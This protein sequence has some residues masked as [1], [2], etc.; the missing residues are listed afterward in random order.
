M[1]GEGMED[2]ESTR[3]SALALLV[4]G[5][6]PAGPHSQ[7]FFFFQTFLSFFVGIFLT[8]QFFTCVETVC[9]SYSSYCSSFLL[10]D[11]ELLDSCQSYSPQTQLFYFQEP[12][13]VHCKVSNGFNDRFRSLLQFLAC[14]GDY[15]SYPV[16]ENN[17]SRTP[18]AIQPPARPSHPIFFKRGVCLDGIVHI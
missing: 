12:K 13:E 4:M 1:F 11:T 18:A 8:L 6:E 10:F 5:W 2:Q 3:N 15:L 14:I 16:H 9:E 17:S 7:N